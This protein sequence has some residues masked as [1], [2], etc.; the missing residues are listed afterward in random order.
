MLFD[1]TR[2]AKSHPLRSLLFDQRQRHH[3]SQNVAIKFRGESKFKN[4]AIQLI[5]APDF[6]ER[7][8]KAQ[9]DP[10]GEFAQKFI[11]EIMPCVRICAENVAWGPFERR[12]GISH[13]Q[14]LKV[15]FGGSSV[16]VTFA[17][18]EIDSPSVIS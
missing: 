16:F 18:G 4:K 12:K 6:D 3:L 7:L 14:A 13:M 2:F 10:D 9:L 1:D 5:N 17:P 15:C 8:K 11:D